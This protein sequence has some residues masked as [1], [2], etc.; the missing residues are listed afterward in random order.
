MHCCSFV[1][2]CSC[3][4]IKHILICSLNNIHNMHFEGFLSISGQMYAPTIYT[5]TTL[6]LMSNYIF[7]L[8]YTVNERQFS[9][10]VSCCIKQL[11][12]SVALTMPAQDFHATSVIKPRPNSL[13]VSVHFLIPLYKSPPTRARPDIITIVSR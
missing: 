8:Y 2:S 12:E 4:F 1:L 5:T 11:R 10:S 13:L 9:A 6:L 7:H 3:N